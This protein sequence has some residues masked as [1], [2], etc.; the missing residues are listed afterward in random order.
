MCIFSGFS[1]CGPTNA[2]LKRRSRSHR[3]R[4]R[5]ERRGPLKICPLSVVAT[6]L[7]L[8]AAAEIGQ[9]PPH[10]QGVCGLGARDWACNEP[11]GSDGRRLMP[12]PAL[13]ALTVEAVTSHGL[14]LISLTGLLSGGDHHGDA[15]ARA[16]CA[17]RWRSMS[18]R[19]K[20]DGCQGKYRD[21]HQRDDHAANH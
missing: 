18:G 7:T 4:C 2:K 14:A 13:T 10:A 3:A 9:Q 19:R 15:G 12:S 6:L 20:A 5:S 8:P 16:G 17:R 21:H 1:Q 11:T